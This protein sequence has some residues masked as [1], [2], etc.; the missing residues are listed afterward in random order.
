M[1]KNPG[2]KK[3]NRGRSA[4]PSDNKQPSK[5][6]NTTQT[7]EPVTTVTST[8]ALPNNKLQENDMEVELTS[9]V[10]PQTEEKGKN[11]E[12]N[13]PL[14]P[15]LSATM[16]IDDS[17]DPT[18]NDIASDKDLFAFSKPQE[19]FFAYCLLEKYRGTTPQNKIAD[20]VD[21]H[22]FDLQSYAGVTRG[23][24][25]DDPT[26]TILKIAFKDQQERDSFCKLQIP[27]LDGATFL[28]LVITRQAPYVPKLSIMM[29]EIPLDATELRLKKRFSKYGNITRIA[30]ET[31]NLWQRATITFDENADFESLDKGDGIFLLNDMIRFY[32]N[33]ALRSLI[34]ERS[35]H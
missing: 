10:N 30:M 24:F 11:K 1:P 25:P 28:P 31:R 16:N 32:R 3:A 5:K 12:V 22:C 29:T 20:L 21:Q 9:V 27:Q 13:T 6:I 18:E 7:D 34:Q 33:D 14:V 15:V 26:K 23:K 2:N 8:S 17:S 35:K 19:I 4:S